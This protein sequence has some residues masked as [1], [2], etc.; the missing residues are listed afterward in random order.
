M[1]SIKSCCFI[2]IVFKSFFIFDL[3]EIV[4]LGL[5]SITTYKSI[6]LDGKQ[7]I[8]LCRLQILLIEFKDVFLIINCYP[9]MHIGY[10]NPHL[11]KFCC[12]CFLF[13]S[14]NGNLNQ[15][16]CKRNFSLSNVFVHC[17]ITLIKKSKKHWKRKFHSI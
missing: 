9:L 15:K 6:N 17:I 16:V 1:Q 12:Y 10:V 14:L 3:P 8:P 13:F 7:N 11:Q 2:I 4:T 5:T